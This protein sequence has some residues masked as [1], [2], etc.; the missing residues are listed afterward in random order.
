MPTG[1]IIG[2][3][4]IP[5]FEVSTFRTFARESYVQRVQEIVNAETPNQ[6]LGRAV[7]S[8]FSASLKRLAPLCKSVAELEYLARLQ[9]IVTSAATNPAE[10]YHEHSF[11]YDK[12]GELTSEEFASFMDPNNH[13]SRLIIAHL[14]A[15]EFVMTRKELEAVDKPGLRVDIHREGYDC[16][17]LMAMDWIIKILESLPPHYHTYAGWLANFVRELPSCT[18]NLNEVWQ[19]F[20]LHKDAVAT[21][22]I[23]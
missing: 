4:L 10:C 3:S 15:V 20:V 5:D 23:D 17:K 13:V 21:P 8:G 22:N 16:R 19:P 7:A 2:S 9:R 18:N 11:L 1:F 12:F 14:L 6:A